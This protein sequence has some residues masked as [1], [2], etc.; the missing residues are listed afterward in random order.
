[1]SCKFVLRFVPHVVAHLAGLSDTTIV[2]IGQNKAVN[3]MQKGL[4]EAETY[5]VP[6]KNLVFH[7][8]QQVW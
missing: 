1:M 7:S 6:T 5:G 2:Y 8:C 3:P 4:R